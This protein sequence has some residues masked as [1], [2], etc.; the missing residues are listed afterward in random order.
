MCTL[1]DVSEVTDVSVLL[2][3]ACT[4]HADGLSSL[5]GRT[6]AVVARHL[7][8]VH[9]PLPSQST[10]STHTHTHPPCD[11]HVTCM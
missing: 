11:H 6:A 1:I 5:Y 9:L 3:V 8:P 10:S 4:A 2:G 7:C